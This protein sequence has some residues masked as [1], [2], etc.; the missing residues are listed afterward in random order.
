MLLLDK[1]KSISNFSL[2]F[3]A[4]SWITWPKPSSWPMG[5]LSIST[6]T[7]FLLSG[8]YIYFSSIFGSFI[9]AKILSS[10]GIAYKSFSIKSTLARSILFDL[11]RTQ[12]T[13][14]SGD[15]LL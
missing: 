10:I 14:P 8:L 4:S 12:S 11:S 5:N 15:L 3:S 13:M 6:L 9:L 2:L 1:T 7:T